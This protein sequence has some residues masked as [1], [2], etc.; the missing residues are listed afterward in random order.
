MLCGHFHLTEVWLNG[1]RDDK[2]VGVPV[3][4]GG[5]PE[6]E[7]GRNKKYIGCCVGFNDKNATVTFTDER[8]RTVNSICIDI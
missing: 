1:Y 5:K 3:I 7:R 6:N 2:N 4:I 8:K